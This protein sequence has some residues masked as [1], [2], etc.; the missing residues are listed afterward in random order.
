MN[1]NYEQMHAEAAK[2]QA[3]TPKPPTTDTF[4]GAAQWASDHAKKPQPGFY[5]NYY[6]VDQMVASAGSPQ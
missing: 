1:D 6:N 2:R 3:P 4:Q 5:D